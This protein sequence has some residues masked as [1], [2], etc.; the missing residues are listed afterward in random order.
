MTEFGNMWNDDTK[1]KVTEGILF[2]LACIW[3]C[4]CSV[5]DPE[6][7]VYESLENDPLPVVT[8]KSA[9]QVFLREATLGIALSPMS[10]K[11]PRRLY[12]CYGKDSDQP[13]TMQL[14]IDLLP[15]YKDG[16]VEVKMTNLLPATL[17][18]CRVYAETRKEKG[19]SDLFKF[20]TST[21]DTDIAWQKVADFPDRTA[22]YNR[23]FTIGTDLYFQ[24]CEMDRQM[25]VGGTAILKFTPVSRT[26]E[27]ITDIPGGKRCD[28]VIYVMNDKVYIGLGHTGGEN[29][30]GV[31]LNDMWEYDPAK[32]SWR[33]MPDSPG[34]YATLMA[35]FVYKD[36]GYLVSTGAMWE[37]YPM[38]V[39]M[40]DPVSGKWNKKADFPGDKVGNT[41]TLVADDRVFV[42]GGSF[43]YGKKPSFSNCLWEYVPDTDTWFRRADFPGT[44]RSN[45]HGFVIDG[46]LYAG[47]GYEETRDDWSDYTRDLWEYLPEQDVWEPRAG[48]TMWKPDYF[49]FSAG[50]DRGGYIGCADY[51]LWMY[52]PEK[53]R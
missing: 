52:S 17:Y 3:F 48:I 7:P 27:K 34:C 4:A 39:M 2:F 30:Y 40:L 28:P 53:D 23:A 25:N 46:R 6:I 44:A 10:S 31:F 26:W 29:G 20:W 51:G 22:L 43:A 37:E 5:V 11:I 21:S 47:Y 41:L 15:L 14:K 42:V 19:Y 32:H 49:T 16:I 9:S 8:I 36:R 35:S 38:T 45:M 50:T 13:D 33:L 18:Y 1:I 12:L 24:E